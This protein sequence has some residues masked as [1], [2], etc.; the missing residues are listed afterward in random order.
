VSGLCVGSRLPRSARAHAAL[1]LGSYPALGISGGRIAGSRKLTEPRINRSRANTGARY[2]DPTSRGWMTLLS[3]SSP[4]G[5]GSVV[6]V[7]RHPW[8][9]AHPGWARG[10][11][12]AWPRRL[13]C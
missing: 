6:Q 12:L 1:P 11:G 3:P 8:W 7:G 10:R 2:G 4:E 5:P 13:A 9:H